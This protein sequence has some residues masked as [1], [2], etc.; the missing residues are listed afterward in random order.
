MKTNRF[1]ICLCVMITMVSFSFVSTVSVFARATKEPMASDGKSN[2]K[3]VFL[4]DFSAETIGQIPS[5]WTVSGDGGFA[6]V[7]ETTLYSTTKKNALKIDDT[8]TNVAGN[9][10]GVSANRKFPSQTAKTLVEL[11][12]KYEKKD[13]LF[14]AFNIDV[15]SGND[16]VARLI[17]WSGGGYLCYTNGSDPDFSPLGEQ[18]LPSGTWNTIKILIDPVTKKADLMVQSDAIKNYANDFGRELNVDKSMGVSVAQGINLHKEY[19][20]G[21]IDNL[22]FETSMYNGTF[23][24]D[25]VKVSSGV[26]NLGTIKKVKPE[27]IPAPIVNEPVPHAVDGIINLNFNGEYMYYSTK[28]IFVN[29]RVM[30]PF[31]N[32]FSLFNMKIDWDE[33]TQT[34]IGTNEFMKIEVR[35]NSDVAVVNG[36]DVLLNTGAVLI[37][38]RLFLP[39]RSISEIMESEV[40]WDEETQTVFINYTQGG[41]SNE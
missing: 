35:P 21:A 9:Y 5:G 12:F 1:M 28:P 20:G 26:T 13:S 7:D 22:I 40:T 41:M 39:V 15:K 37:D 30:V 38:D 16:I 25:Y 2:E 8:T 4:D 6:T 31:R 32:V 33:N 17:V 18:V 14:C 10:V 23:Y 27:P 3:I 24:L 34:A 19:K 36:S 11:K 29:E